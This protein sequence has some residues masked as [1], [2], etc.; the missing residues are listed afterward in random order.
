M[1]Q[2]LDL[3]QE[4]GERWGVNIVWLEYNPTLPEKFEIVSHRT[5]SRHGEPFE[6]VL[7]EAPR[8]TM[9]TRG[10]VGPPR[11]TSTRRAPTPHGVRHHPIAGFSY[12][13]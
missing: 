4:C 8:A 9:A 6:R 1:P 12:I 3:V 10:T 13:L 2:T 5:A 11:R 7:A